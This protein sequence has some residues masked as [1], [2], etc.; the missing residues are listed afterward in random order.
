MTELRLKNEY[1]ANLEAQ[2]MHLEKIDAYREKIMGNNNMTL[3][4]FTDALRINHH[5]QEINTLQERNRLIDTYLTE[6]WKT[7]LKSKNSKKK[8]KI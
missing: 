2:L 1:E 5:Q 6:L 8:S 7:K 3:H 4:E